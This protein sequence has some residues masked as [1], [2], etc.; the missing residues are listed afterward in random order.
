MLTIRK[1]IV[2][3]WF[4]CFGFVLSWGN[5]PVK[6]S[7]RHEAFQSF[8][9]VSGRVLGEAGEPLP[10]ASV[11]IRQLVIGT[12]SSLE[13]LFNL[14]RV[15]YGSHEIEVSYIGFE[16]YRTTIEVNSSSLSLG[17][18][19]LQPSVNTLGEVIVTGSL[20]G[21][22]RAFNQQK[23]A[24]NIKTIVSADLIGRF[25][26]IN[27]GEAMQRVSGV[28]IE[29]DNGEGSIVKIRGTPQNFTTVSINGEQIPTTD[30]GGGRTEGL[31][32]ISADQLASME[33]S[34]AITPEMDGDAVGGAINLITPTAASA[35]GR[36][37][38]SIGGGYNDLFQRGSQ[39]VRLKYDRRFADNKF[40]IL[41]GG[42]YYNTV[43]GEERFEA[44]Y[45][46]RRIGS[47]DD[48]NSFRANVIDDYRLRPLLNERT[49][50]G[51]NATFDYRFND[52][53][54]VI[55]KA[56]YNKLED[57]SLRRRIR[58]RPRNNY[59]DPLNPDIAGPDNDVRVRRDINDR[60]IDREN[61]TITF[62]GKH[63]LGT[64]GQLDYG[65][66]Y[67][68]S[69]RVLRSDRFVFRERDLTLQLTRDGDFTLFSS[70]DFDFED[71]AAY[72][73]NSFQQDKP[74]LNRG[75]NTVAKI[76]LTVPFNLGKNAG[77]FKTGGKY[78]DLD[79]IR[80]RNTIEYNEFNG[81][82][83]LTQVFDN[84]ESSI[85]DGRY[86]MGR[87]PDPQRAMQHF[88]DNQAAYQIDENAS[89]INS[90]SFFFDAGEDVYAAYFQGKL[91]FNKFRVLAGVRYEKTDVNYDALRLEIE[92]PAQD[93]APA[94]PISSEPVS[95]SNSYD[96]FLPMVHLRYELNDRTNLR[97]AYTQ[98]YAR[99]ELQDLVPSQNINFADQL[100][101]TGN[102][103]LL[104]ASA[105]NLD[106]LFESY[107]KG[108]GVIS[109]GVFYKRIENFI[110]D[111][112]SN[113]DFNNDV[114]LQTE[115]INGDEAELLGV[116]LNFTKKLDFLP[117]FLSGL[118]VFLN[119]TWVDSNSSFEFFD[120]DTE[121]TL[122]RDDVS[123]VGQ[124]DN[125]WN[126]AL[127][128]DLGGFS[129][130]ASLNYNGRSL[131]SFS[132]DPEQDFF[133]EERYQLDVNASQKIS[134]NLTVFVEFVN[135]TNEPNLEFQSVR[136]QVTNY[137]IY[138]WSARF[139]L[140]FKF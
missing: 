13:G 20:E 36:I 127:S 10:G 115:P 130:R 70:P 137:E 75:D 55:F 120:E 64:F 83:N 59:N 88:V 50:I 77:E 129:A 82:Y 66:N 53:S 125:T 29:R 86:Q 87:F 2:P 31:A 48:P 28:T 73:F 7:S 133:L 68:R 128:Y 78:R 6:I 114:F 42:S 110:F 23:N 131:L 91:Q 15:P 51:V 14:P 134:D 5:E 45:R 69:E 61:I 40:G 9:A 92:P 37:K 57:E 126:A 104:P 139:G 35:K 122:V 98:S 76:N 11:V 63:P 3:I 74:I 60:V 41:F 111:Q 16:P 24:D 100:L 85:F 44:T 94:V 67:T 22:Q 112:I 25:P 33:V 93:G 109:G 105:D 117:G 71:Y 113:V 17:D 90:E 8:G 12:S 56:I 58:F 107:L 79:N 62:D 96:F 21:Q 140:N 54:Q 80:R 95:G 65:I 135:L 89:R 101:T 81:P 124:A 119:Y 38:G 26:D 18:I 30:E 132:D 49:R 123:F 72:D 108:A 97:F 116:E 39:I 99:P 138:D 46:N 32:L 136:S 84:N 43:N 103:E 19:V 1:T 34:K 102:P 27:V 118:G 52:N 4:L 106:L 47:E 121:E